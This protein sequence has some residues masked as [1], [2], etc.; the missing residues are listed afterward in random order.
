MILA[1]TVLL[2]LGW[3]TEAGFFTNIWAS[4]TGFLIGVPFALVGLA[5]VTSQREETATRD[6]VQDISIVAWEQ[7][8]DAVYELC[9][10]DRHDAIGEYS[11][12]VQIIHDQIIVG[13][14]NF[15]ANLDDTRSNADAKDLI[16]F[17]EYEYQLWAAEFMK[18][19]EKVG[20]SIEL[21]WKWIG[22][23]R[24]WN[25][26]DQ[27]VRLQRLEQTLPQMPREYANQLQQ[28][29]NI[30]IH[31]MRAFFIAHEGPNPEQN[32]W[33]NSSMFAAL[34]FTQHLI[35][36][37]S[38]FDSLGKAMTGREEMFPMKPITGYL[39]AVEESQYVLR[40]ILY[41][42]EALDREVEWPRKFALPH[43]RNA[44]SE[45][46]E[47]DKLREAGDLR[48]KQIEYHEKLRRRP[49]GH[50][51]GSDLRRH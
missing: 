17:L 26:L 35:D 24:D 29:M 18:I 37:V 23:V 46:T 43:G 41:T 21:Q 16:K 9:S 30:D 10:E 8:R 33:S 34:H 22:V 40:N 19:S 28:R 25:T 20:N 1:G 2:G 5:T 15:I 44:R 51:S 38:D 12:R 7:F 6:R 45:K 42:V 11:N 47:L 49:K 13:V 27:Y 32:L 3:R 39:E 14:K 31:P 48:M 4:F 50:R 36:E